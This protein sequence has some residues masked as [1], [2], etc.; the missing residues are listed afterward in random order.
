MFIFNNG[1][2]FLLT[3][4][5]TCPKGFFAFDRENGSGLQIGI[6]MSNHPIFVPIKESVS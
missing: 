3:K 2:S 6:K 5:N 4:M 1:E